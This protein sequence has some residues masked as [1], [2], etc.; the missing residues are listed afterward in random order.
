M[1]ENSKQIILTDLVILL[2]ANVHTLRPFFSC[3]LKKNTFDRK[4]QDKDNI[5]SFGSDIDFRLTV[6]VLRLDKL[7]PG[8]FVL[9]I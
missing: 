7:S 9:Y 4:P 1:A 5:W 8:N 6:E 2:F 3:A